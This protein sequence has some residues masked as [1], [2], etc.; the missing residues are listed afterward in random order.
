MKAIAVMIL[1]MEG[2]ERFGPA[3][4]SWINS[5]V[6]ATSRASLKMRITGALLA[7]AGDFKSCIQTGEESSGRVVVL[8]NRAFL[9]RLPAFRGGAR[10][11]PGR[12]KTAAERN[13]GH[14]RF[15]RGPFRPSCRRSGPHARPAVSRSGRP[16]STWASA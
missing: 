15:R 12:E 9:V 2:E 4:G 14:H 8:D 10:P 16:C 1:D 11:L 13:P 3:L 6:C 7:G 5:A